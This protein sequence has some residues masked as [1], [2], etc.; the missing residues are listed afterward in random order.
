[1]KSNGTAKEEFRFTLIELLV[2]IAI[3][4]VLAGM[5]LPALSKVKDTSYAIKC[6]SNFGQAG[7]VI[8]LYMEDYNGHMPVATNATFN[9]TNGCMKDYWPK[10]STVGNIE[11]FGALYNA[12][13]TSYNSL[14]ACPAHKLPVAAG[15]YFWTMALNNWFGSYYIATAPT[16]AN[17]MSHKFKYPSRLM[18]MGDG[19]S[20]TFNYDKPLTHASYAIQFR[21]N[22]AANFLFVDGHVQAMKA[23]EIPN[24]E[25]ENGARLKPFWYPP[26]K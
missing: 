21:H 12:E 25:A 26:A 10:R 20:W 14:F 7:K 1:M 2:V 15:T 22:K 3:I 18:Y 17:F 4:A 6:A 24:H 19:K 5:L 16:P 11:Q 9:Y 23:A 8:L 13:G